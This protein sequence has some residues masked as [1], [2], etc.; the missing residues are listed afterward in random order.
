MF[1]CQQHTTRNQ[2]VST[3]KFNDA[4]TRE[5]KETALADHHHT[6]HHHSRKYSFIIFYYMYRC[7]L[8]FSKRF[9][10][11][12]GGDVVRL[13]VLIQNPSRESMITRLFSTRASWFHG[14]VAARLL[15]LRRHFV[16]LLLLFFLLS[17]FWSLV[18][19][20]RLL[21]LLLLLRRR[22]AQTTSLCDEATINSFEPF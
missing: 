2:H 13:H 16:L 22:R 1:L 19:Y 5:R 4:E 6:S 21:S 18:R 9:L 10:L 7:F 17:K 3:Q 11:L 8:S 20:G 12:V 14:I 15:N